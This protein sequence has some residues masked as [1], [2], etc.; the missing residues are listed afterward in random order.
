MKVGLALAGNPVTRGADVAASGAPDGRKGVTFVGLDGSPLPMNGGQSVDGD[1]GG[2]TDG[3]V[4][5]AA[6]FACVSVLANT[7]PEPPLRVFDFDDERLESHPI[8]EILEEPDRE[9]GMSPSD[10]SLYMIYHAAL[11]GAC[12]LQKL[13]SKAGRVV[14][15]RPYHVGNIT[16]VRGAG[17]QLVAAYDYRSNRAGETATRLDPKDVIVFRWPSLDLDNAHLPL[18]PLAPIA[19]ERGTDTELTRFV[20][21]VLYNDAV[22]RGLIRLPE[23]MGADTERDD[24]LRAIW[25]ERFGRGSRGDVAVMHSG[26]D[27]TR[28][29]MNFSELAVQALRDTPEA[30]IAAAFGVPAILAGLNVGL[31]RST[32]SNTAEARK[33]L[34][35]SRL[36]PLWERA[37]S[38]LTRG[39]R[40]EFTGADR[41]SIKYDL[42]R[43]AALQ[44]SQ[45]ARA[46][47]AGELYKSGVITRNEARRMVGREDVGGGDVFIG[48]PLPTTTILTGSTE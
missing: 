42:S 31:A 37:G 14:G 34:T 30:R 27:Y 10:L 17:G 43:I 41:I 32:F 48:T 7:F 4:Q 11:G 9:N 23:S 45:D 28:V 39:L 13:R 21:E 35:D 22:P 19:K 36:V 24:A 16:P 40:D 29:G 44:E 38:A 15:L 1:A 20:L 46:K 2:P 6:V 3:H 8:S 33:F 12:Y 5:N 18:S 25:R 26:G 47:R